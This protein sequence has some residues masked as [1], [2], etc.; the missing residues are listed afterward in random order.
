MDCLPFPTNIPILLC[1]I[2]LSIVHCNQYNSIPVSICCVRPVNVPVNVG[3][4]GISSSS[5]CSLYVS[6]GMGSE[7][8]QGGESYNGALGEDGAEIEE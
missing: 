2:I 5:P 8:V 3:D 7:E 1:S 6:Y 4:S